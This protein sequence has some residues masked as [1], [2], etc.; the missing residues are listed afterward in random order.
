M[1]ARMTPMLPLLLAAA[2]FS[3][4]PV[5]LQSGSYSLG[6]YDS[7]DAAGLYDDFIVEID[8]EEG[9]FAIES[10]DMALELGMELLPERDWVSVCPTNFSSTDLQTYSLLGSMSLGDVSI[11]SPIV[12]P[13]G[14]AGDSGKQ[15]SRAWIGKE[16]Q[17]LSSVRG[18][19]FYLR[20]ME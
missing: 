1:F 14:C 18:G 3:S 4:E 16:S 13:D 8:V 5:Y 19:L 17:S 6:E 11:D 2:C 9:Q 7:G 12:Y 15:A 10:D 20:L